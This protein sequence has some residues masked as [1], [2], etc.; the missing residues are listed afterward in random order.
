[1]LL[2]DKCEYFKSAW[3]FLKHAKGADFASSHGHWNL[4][5]SKH[6]KQSL[7]KVTE[8]KLSWPIHIH[9]SAIFT[10]LDDWILHDSSEKGWLKLSNSSLN[11]ELKPTKK[12]INQDWLL[13]SINLNRL[14]DQIYLN[15]VRN[16]NFNSCKLLRNCSFIQTF[17]TLKCWTLISRLE[18]SWN[19]TFIHLIHKCKWFEKGTKA[20]LSIWFMNANGLRKE[21]R[22]LITKKLL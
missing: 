12:M 17:C 4:L 20:A 8:I 10:P 15:H 3:L 11:S 7:I 14:K 18:L 16:L 19:N 2:S 9:F 22:L 21:Y 5:F 6:F 1:M 13:R